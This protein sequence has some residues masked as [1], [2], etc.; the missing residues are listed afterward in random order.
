[1]NIQKIREIAAKKLKTG[2]HNVWI[3]PAE[4]T[5]IKKAM[6]AEDIK[7]LI[8]EKKIY[9]KKNNAQSKARARA[10]KEK[11]KKGRKKGPGK[12]TGTKKTRT[13]KKNKWIQDVRAQRKT[14]KKMK[15]EGTIT[16]QYRKI[17]S[18]IKGGYFKG[19]KYIEALAT[20]KG[21]TKK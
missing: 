2:K 21:G 10:L 17:Y 20:K 4:T 9:K 13:R 12:K 6:T 3:N 1:M 14:L 18:K 8:K 7:E 16:K 15:K 19:K 5:E 11:K